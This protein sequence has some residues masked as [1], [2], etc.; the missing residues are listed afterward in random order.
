[1]KPPEHFSGTSTRLDPSGSLAAV[2]RLGES[3]HVGS[4]GS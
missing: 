3:D 1:M 2:R 4:V